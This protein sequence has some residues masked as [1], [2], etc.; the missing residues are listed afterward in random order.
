M[1]GHHDSL[2]RQQTAGL[3][4]YRT[5]FPFL[6]VVNV[7]LYLL[8]EKNYFQR[9]ITTEVLLVPQDSYFSTVFLLIIYNLLTNNHKDFV[10]YLHEQCSFAPK[11]VTVV[12]NLFP[13]LI[14]RTGFYRGEPPHYKLLHIFIFYFLAF[15]SNY[16]FYVLSLFYYFDF[17]FFIVVHFFADFC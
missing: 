16:L 3:L 14:H 13:T 8:L 1:P 15:F 6:F 12:H 11:I 10:C 9:Q 2:I 4:D 7:A 17:H 5:T